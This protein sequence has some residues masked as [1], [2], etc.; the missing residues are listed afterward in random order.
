MRNFQKIFFFFVLALA[1]VGL[2]SC[3]RYSEPSPVE[4]SGFPHNYPAN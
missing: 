2:S 3:G 1:V 4:G